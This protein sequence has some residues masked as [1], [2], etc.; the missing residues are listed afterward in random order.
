M[1]GTGEKRSIRLNILLKR[2]LKGWSEE[3]LRMK[4]ATWGVKK[5]TEDS[6]MKELRI[7]LRQKLKMKVD[8]L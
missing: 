6:Y 7:F 4:I 5:P 1:A 8:D 2:A 3:D